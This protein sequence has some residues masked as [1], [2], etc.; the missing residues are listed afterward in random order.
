MPYEK[1]DKPDSLDRVRG[2]RSLARCSGFM[3]RRDRKLAEKARELK[4]ADEIEVVFPDKGL[5]DAVRR[6]RYVVDDKI[7]YDGPLTRGHLKRMKELEAYDEAIEDL[8]G[9]EHAVNLTFVGLWR[10]QT[11]GVSPLASL[12]KLTALYLDRNE[13]N[14]VS[15]LASLTNLTALGIH[16]GPSDITPLASLTNLKELYLGGNNIGDYTPLKHLKIVNELS[17]SNYPAFWS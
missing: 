15:P 6:E 2:D 14:D 10:N 7:P 17:D 4:L 11:C 1:D 9:L 13:S 5:E 16:E 3:A 8:T 12:T